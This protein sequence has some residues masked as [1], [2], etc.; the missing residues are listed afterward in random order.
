MF[1]QEGNAQN[2]PAQRS[3]EAS[4]SHRTPATPATADATARHADASHADASHANASHANA[5][6]AETSSTI[7]TPAAD[8]DDEHGHGTTADAAAD[9]ADGSTYDAGRTTYRTGND[10]EQSTT[11]GIR[12]VW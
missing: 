5:T 4:R 2:N 12:D 1:Q 9:D 10:D 3:G 7:Q 11:R 8:A 6:Y